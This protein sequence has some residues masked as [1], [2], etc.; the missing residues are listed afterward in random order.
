MV[1]TPP[2]PPSL[3]CRQYV[4]LKPTVYKTSF[5]DVAFPVH[6]ARQIVLNV[7]TRKIELGFK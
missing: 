6:A 4:T 5:S 1:C 2:P 3:F 7:F